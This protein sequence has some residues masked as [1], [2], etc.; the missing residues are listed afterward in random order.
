MELKLQVP[1]MERLWTVLH[2]YSYL[3]NGKTEA[4]KGK[5]A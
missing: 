2:P 1:E 5:T 4:K 3:F